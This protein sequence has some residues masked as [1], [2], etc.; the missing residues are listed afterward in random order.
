MRKYVPK[1]AAAAVLAAVLACTGCESMRP[2]PKTKPASREFIVRNRTAF[3]QGIKSGDLESAGA[4]LSRLEGRKV[5]VAE[6]RNQLGLARRIDVLMARGQAQIKDR[7]WPGMA[8][9]REELVKARL[10][11]YSGE[12]AWPPEY[13]DRLESEYAA[14]M[15]AAAAADETLGK[16]WQ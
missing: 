2:E 5:S 13:I 8:A 7:D 14:F 1:V 16:D 3:E 11:V 4:A 10:E 6:Q 12:F 9:T 15:K